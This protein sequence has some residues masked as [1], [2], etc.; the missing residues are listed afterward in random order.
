MRRKYLLATLLVFAM[1]VLLPQWAFAVTFNSSGE[2]TPNVTRP[3]QYPSGSSGGRR[4]D[5]PALLDLN[6][7]EKG[8]LLRSIELTRLTSLQARVALEKLSELDDKK[9]TGAEMKAHLLYAQK[10]L[11]VMEKAGKRLDDSVTLVKMAIEGRYGPEK[12]LAAI[13]ELFQAV[14]ALAEE[15]NGVPSAQDV[16]NNEFNKVGRGMKRSFNN[17][18]T[19]LSNGAKVVI[20]FASTVGKTIKN[21]VSKVTG[22]VGSAHHKIGTVVGQKNWAT[23]MAATKFTVGMVGAGAGLVVAVVSL[24]ATTTGA[25]LSVGAV[26]IYTAANI[27]TAVS[28]A[29]DMNSISG[30]S[31]QAGSNLDN[32]MTRIN[33]GTAIIGLVTSGSGGDVIVNTISLTGNEIVG[34]ANISE[35]TPEELSGY[36]D[37][38]DR[39]KFMDNF[40][41]KV[42]YNEPSK[43]PEKGGENEGSGSSG[44]SCGCGS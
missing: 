17:A 4:K 24:P 7:P 14:P 31:S 8:R 12:R 36:L 10:S 9:V 19:K 5:A 27:G 2:N 26:A 38:E 22:L 43:N 28:F 1:A 3:T 29:N 42:K 39:K 41:S 20:G 16:I 6:G 15:Y 25:V 33:Q 23:A 13:E 21:G 18:M 44:G 11:E 30:G 35:M 37:E 40:N 32:T 34:T